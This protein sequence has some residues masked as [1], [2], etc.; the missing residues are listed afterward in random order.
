MSSF[1]KSNIISRQMVKKYF[2]LLS[3]INHGKLNSF[4]NMDK[5]RDKKILMSDKCNNI[6]IVLNNSNCPSP[7]L[8]QITPKLK[9]S[10]INSKEYNSSNKY[11]SSTATDD[12]IY[13]KVSKNNL[14]NLNC[15]R[16]I[17][18]NKNHKEIKPVNNY[19]MKIKSLNKNWNYNKKSFEV[20]QTDINNSNT[21]SIEH[22]KKSVSKN[23]G[24]KNK[25]IVLDVI[26][27]D[28]NISK[29]NHFNNINIYKIPEELHFYFVSLAQK[30]K[31]YE[32]NLEGE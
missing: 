14:N 25:K 30:G 9:L 20:F 13:K 2:N 31:N 11:D 23:K 28:V 16:K 12:L 15:I 24:S 10:K 26:N 4:N 5:K 29:E 3:P 21:N 18:I 22:I 1:E 8:F 17:Y 6:K 27:K 19:H 7:N 32:N